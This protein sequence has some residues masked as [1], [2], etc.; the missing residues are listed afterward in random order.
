MEKGEFIATKY[1][2]GYST[3]EISRL[4]EQCFGESI[5]PT[6]ILRRIKRMKENGTLDATRDENEQFL[7]QLEQEA[8]GFFKIGVLDIETTGLWADFGY[9]L[10]AVIKNL[11]STNNYDIFR[12]DEMPSYRDPEK[13]KS[14]DYWHRVDREL[15]LKI[16]D[17]YEKYDIIIH[18]NGR[19]FDIKFLNTRMLK[20]EIPLLPEMKQL[21]IYQIAKHRLRLRSKRLDA[22]KEYLEIDNLEEGH[23][24]EYWQMAG[25]G[26]KEGFDFV[27]DHCKRDV[28]RLAA[29]AKRLKVYINYIKK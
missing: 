3:P 8:G 29:V 11:D 14:I 21:D 12:L 10:C 18:F 6:T 7:D 19:N 24:W 13:R 5:H 1:N 16:R 23:R 28:D 25:A 2:E 17:V 27:V 4:Y 22:L 26:M 15:L 9:V 20:N